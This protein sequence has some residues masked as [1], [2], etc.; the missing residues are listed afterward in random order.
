[1]DTQSLRDL[2]VEK[3]SSDSGIDHV[4]SLGNKIHVF[5]DSTEFEVVIR[6]IRPERRHKSDRSQDYYSKNET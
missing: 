1:M 5:V 6:T 4:V 2:I 3:L